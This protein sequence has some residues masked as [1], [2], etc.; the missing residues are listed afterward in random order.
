MSQQ[1]HLLCVLLGLAA[2]GCPREAAAA[3]AHRYSFT[4][5]A[6]DSIGTAHGTVVDAGTPSHVFTNGQLDL[7]A[8]TGQGSNAATLTDAFV[9][10]PN[11]LISEAASNGISGAFSLELWATIS[12]ARTWQRFVDLGSANGGENVSD[13]GAATDYVYIAANHGRF[14]MGVGTEVHEANQTVAVTE[15]GQTG[16]VPTNVQQHIVG[17]YDHNDT[18][19]GANGTMRLYRNGAPIGA[20]PIPPNIDLNTFTNDN[21]WL[22]RS[23]WNDPIFDGSFNEFRIYDHA[24]TA[25]EITNNTF[26]G[27]DVV[28]SGQL[29]SLTVNTNSGQVTMTNNTNV[30]VNLDF[31]RISSAGGALSL[32]GW[33]SLDTQNYDAVDGPDAGTIA[34][35]SD[36]E[37][38][39]DAGGSNASQLVELFLGENGSSLAPSETL[40]LGNAFNTSVFGGGNNGDLQFTF[41]LVGGAQFTGSVMYVSGP[42]GV[43]GDYNNNGVVDAADYVLWRN[44]GPLQNEGETPG[45]IT[46]EDYTFWRSR[47]GATPGGGAAAT[48]AVP[49]P[50]LT[51]VPILVAVA[52]L[53]RQRRKLFN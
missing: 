35:D 9:D 48:A 20:A 39:D 33:N 8:N 38:W 2:L 25:S 46:A 19:S 10:L 14:G 30:A 21:N 16:A 51:S 50:G 52:T 44:G 31:Y 41:G 34:G 15:T 6:N 42:A 5:D 47:F 37:G 49:E 32:S 29:P 1:I 27:P 18:S 28:G 40:N 36:G 43:A 13:G 26:F 3:L 12:T 7:S 45:S 4:S 24:L 22:G 23:Q 17:T 53:F 11:G